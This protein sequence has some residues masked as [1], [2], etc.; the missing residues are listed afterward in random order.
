MAATYPELFAAASLYS[1][2]PAGCFMSSSN[3]VDAWNS[4]CAEGQIDETQA[5]WTSVVKA[6]YPGYTGSRPKMA[7]YHGSADA[8]LYP[9]NFNE[10]IKEW[11][12]VFGYSLTP[13]STTPNDPLPNYTT[14]VYGPDVVGV[15]ADGVGHTVPVQGA[16]D[17]A[18][19]GF[20]GGSTTGGGGGSGTTTSVASSPTATGGSGGGSAGTVA[21]WGQCGGIGYTGPTACASPYTCHVLNSYYSQCY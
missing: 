20:T 9:P 5:Y 7:I 2:V 17:L 14:Y 11:T 8:T 6:M 21:E 16:S 18:W 3:Q 19:F 15:Y 4:T 12:G 13:Q 1:G 10:T